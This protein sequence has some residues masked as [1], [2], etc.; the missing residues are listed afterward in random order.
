[1]KRP[2]LI[3]TLALLVSF[4]L[5]EAFSSALAAI[6]SGT[7]SAWLQAAGDT[8]TA[9]VALVLAALVA[10]MND[11]SGRWPLWLLD[12]GWLRRR[13]KLVLE[14]SHATSRP[15]ARRVTGLVP[16]VSMSVR[17]TDSLTPTQRAQTSA[18]GT[19]HR[20]LREDGQGLTEYALVLV[21]VAMAAVLLLGEVGSAIAAL[22]DTATDAFS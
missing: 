2:A 13:N 10:A 21:L 11:G 18:V 1:M 5:A 20:W 4:P 9:V 7:A 22:I 14:D 6:E 15:G 19:S 16:D 8:S 3:F 17:T 12:R